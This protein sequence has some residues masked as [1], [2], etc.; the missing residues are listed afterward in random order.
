M[1][2]LLLDKGADVNA[3]WATEGI[4]ALIFASQEGH[5][6][7]VK[8][9][10]DKGADVNAKWATEGMTALMM[11]SWEGHKDVVKLLLDKGADVNAKTITE[12]MTA[13]MMASWEGHKDVVKLLHDKGA[14][15][16]V[17]E[18]ALYVKWM[19]LKIVNRIIHLK[20]EM[21]LLIYFAFFLLVMLILI[22][23]GKAKFRKR[24]GDRLNA[25]GCKIVMPKFPP[26]Q[27]IRLIYNNREI[28]L[29]IYHCKVSLHIK[30]KKSGPFLKPKPLFTDSHI[31]Q[32]RFY[33]NS[34]YVIPENEYLKTTSEKNKELLDDFVKKADLVETGQY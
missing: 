14:Q 17:P 30:L 20:R 22:P 12:G 2:K 18:M 34:F 13:L 11:A 28:M 6:D 19:I 32:Y 23:I 8:L 29:K 16:T 1:V 33:G 4:T 15:M 10:L 25:I 21:R 31:G 5:T 24:Y 26:F 9:L 27:A 3:K 7:V